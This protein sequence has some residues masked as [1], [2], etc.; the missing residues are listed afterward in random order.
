[1]TRTVIACAGSLKACEKEVAHYKKV[2]GAALRGTIE[3]HR[4]IT[5]AKRWYGVNHLPFWN[6]RA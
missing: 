4:C 2:M 6:Y 3:I 5:G 1:M